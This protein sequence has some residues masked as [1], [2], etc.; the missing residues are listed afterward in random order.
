MMFN[1]LIGRGLSC[2]SKIP[3]GL[4]TISAQLSSTSNKT[5][6]L[7]RTM[8]SSKDKQ[9]LY[10]PHHSRGLG[11]PNKSKDKMSQFL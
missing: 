5:S 2:R 10:W 11:Y 7:A 3:C 6:W 1:K 9:I 8:T 4:P